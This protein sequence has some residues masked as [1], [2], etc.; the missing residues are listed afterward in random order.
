MIRW[1]GLSATDVALPLL[2]LEFFAFPVL[3]LS[4]LEQDSM[5]PISRP[6]LS[7]L[8]RVL[9]GWLVFYLLS[10]LVWGVC[11]AALA[12]GF[13]NSAAVSA[14]VS[15]PLLASGILIYGRLIGRLGWLIVKRVPVQEAADD[16]A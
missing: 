14:L 7:S 3:L 4:A 1:Q 6:V 2:A 13:R 8:V 12:F 9:D 10:A 11:G 16:R 5:L 15:G